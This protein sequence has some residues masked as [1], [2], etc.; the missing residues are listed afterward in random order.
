MIMGC[1][2]I[3]LAEYLMQKYPGVQQLMPCNI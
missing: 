1:N 2:A 3:K